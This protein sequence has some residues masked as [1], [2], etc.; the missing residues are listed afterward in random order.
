MEMKDGR[1]GDD[2]GRTLL[3]RGCNLGGSSKVP[4]T[5]DGATWRSGSLA[6]PATVSFVGRPFPLE[7]AEQ[8]LDR[9]ASWGFTFL[10]LVV[11]WEAIEHAGP[12][13]YDEAYLAYLRKLLKMAETRGISVFMD[14]HQDVWSR[15]TGGDGAPAWTLEKLGLRLDRLAPTGSALTHQEHGDPY[16]RMAWITNYNRYAAATLFTLFFAGDAYAPEARIDGESAQ[17]WLQERY[18]AAFRHA[19]RRLKDCRAIVGWGTM[20]EPHPGF[21]GYRDLTGLENNQLAAGPIPSAFQAMAAASGYP[22]EVPVYR[23]GLAGVRVV[24]KQVINATGLSLFNDGFECPWKTAGVWTDR[25]GRPELLKKDYFFQANGR[26]VRFVDDFLKP[27]MRRFIE[28]QRQV[29]EKTFI[30][31]EGRP[32]GDH[33]AWT[34]QDGG[35]VVNAFHWYDEATLFSKRF[36]PWVS[37]RADTRKPVLGPGRVARSFYEQLA[38]DVAWSRLRMGGMPCLLGEFGLPFDLNG[39]RAF[40]DGDYRRHETALGMYYDAIDANLLHATIWNYTPDNDHEHGDHWNGEDLSIFS[41]GQA[42]A[43]DG[44]RRPYPLA[45]AG[46]PLAF[47]WDRKRRIFRFRYQAEPGIP[48]PTEIYL[49]RDCLGDQ[50][51]VILRDEAGN[52]PP[53]AS[54]TRDADRDR[55]FIDAGG[56]AGVLSLEVRGSTEA[57]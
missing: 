35:N 42:R 13:V 17:A 7:E 46:V 5:P 32:G 23:T 15:W 54:T 40:R 19:F 21:I 8:H 25:D 38:D 50:P 20:N 51:S 30:F 52:P 24:G 43:M 29:H 45:T 41:A 10:R 34:D 37:V 16:P 44:W 48:A 18:L 14:P 2:A 49:P 27:F 4:L 11:T 39:R 57:R 53:G 1:I 36:H 12:G 6:D 47:S 9:L 22:M 28:R 26:P 33:P 31:I 55:L 3:L 56:Y